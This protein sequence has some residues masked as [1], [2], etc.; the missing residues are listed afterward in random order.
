VSAQ[1]ISTLGGCRRVLQVPAE[2]PSFG[3]ISTRHEARQP[4]LTGS[5]LTRK[6]ETFDHRAMRT[7]GRAAG[8]T[9]AEGDVI[10]APA[11]EDICGT[12]V[13]R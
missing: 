11:S 8:S 4:S 7:A 9:S 2:V 12:F 1:G 13:D 6:D 10:D 3:C 5:I